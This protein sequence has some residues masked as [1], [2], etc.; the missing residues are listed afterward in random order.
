MIRQSSSTG[1]QDASGSAS[2]SIAL[3]SKVLTTHTFPS[4]PQTGYRSPDI[5]ACLSDTSGMNLGKMTR[6]EASDPGNI[7]FMPDISC[8]RCRFVYSRSFSLAK[9]QILFSSRAND[10]RYVSAKMS[11]RNESSPERTRLL[12]SPGSSD[13]CEFGAATD[14]LDRTLAN[15]QLPGSCILASK[16]FKSRY[17]QI[18]DDRS[19]S[20]WPSPS[21]VVKVRHHSRPPTVL[22][23]APQSFPRIATHSREPSPG[24]YWLCCAS[25]TDSMGQA[26]VMA[27]AECHL[28]AHLSDMPGA[29][30]SPAS[31]S[32]TAIPFPKSDVGSV[33]LLPRLD[34]LNESAL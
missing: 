15:I 19:L 16:S 29:L 6:G 3:P 18:F 20:R 22:S 12:M 27:I 28:F 1:C 24:I 4:R 17:S 13:R 32:R 7:L 2:S 11:H 31:P 5:R 25:R 33:D 14:S 10:P 8:L 21:Q 34:F 26:D 30:Q 23:D 9:E